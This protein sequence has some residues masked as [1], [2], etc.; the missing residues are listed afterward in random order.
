MEITTESNLP[1]YDSEEEKESS[2]WSFDLTSSEFSGSI[3]TSKESQ[4][5]II[6]RQEREAEEAIKAI[7]EQMKAKMMLKMKGKGS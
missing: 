3:Q 2:V 7:Q 1:E 4:T 5:E 6:A